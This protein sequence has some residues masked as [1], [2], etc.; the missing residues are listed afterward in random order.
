MG[1]D[2]LD[3]ISSWFWNMDDMALFDRALPLPVNSD[4][5]RESWSPALSHSVPPRALWF[6]AEDTEGAPLGV[7]GLQAINY[8][9][10]DAVLPMF[11]SERARGMGLA[12]AITSRLLDL[13]FNRMRLHRVTT[14][15][16]ED[17]TTTRHVLAKLGFAE[18][19]RQRGGWFVD[20]TRLDV[21]HS[22]ILASEWVDRRAEIMDVLASPGKVRLSFMGESSA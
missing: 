18:E 2:D 17:N 10:G 1:L 12:T 3:G 4:S 6:V 20:G 19:G 13:A 9:H 16:R 8:I 7:G 5:L 22:G 14:F 21:V 15:F 11:I